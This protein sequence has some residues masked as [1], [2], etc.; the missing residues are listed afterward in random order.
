MASC[1]KV[2]RETIKHVKFYRDLHLSDDKH[3]QK[4]KMFHVKH[5]NLFNLSDTIE[6]FFIIRL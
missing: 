2:S 6:I 4:N 3:S 5:I 1:S